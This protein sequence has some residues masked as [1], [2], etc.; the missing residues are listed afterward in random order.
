M[1]R[2]IYLSILVLISV[3]LLSGKKNTTTIQL[4]L[5]TL[6]HEVRETPFPLNGATVTQNPPALMWPDQFP[7]LG[8]VLDGVEET[9]HKPHV[10]YKIRLSQDPKFKKEVI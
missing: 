6:M 2:Y 9:A 1:R 8:P 7:H 10:I 4:D 5:P 3:L